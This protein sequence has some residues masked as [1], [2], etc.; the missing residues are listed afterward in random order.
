MCIRDRYKKRTTLKAVGERKVRS[1]AVPGGGDFVI[2]PK[3]PRPGSQRLPDDTADDNESLQSTLSTRINKFMAVQNKKFLL[4]LN[5]QAMLS[6]RSL[7]QSCKHQSI[8]CCSEGKIIEFTSNISALSYHQQ[9]HHHNTLILCSC[10]KEEQYCLFS[11]FKV[12]F[13]VKIRNEDLRFLWLVGAS[14]IMW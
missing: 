11:S 10:S 13:P 3:I 7:E 1:T 8:D 6:N 9:H 2:R 12:F 14:V 4:D 5:A